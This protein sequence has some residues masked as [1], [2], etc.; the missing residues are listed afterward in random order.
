MPTICPV[1]FGG[2]SGKRKQSQAQ[3]YQAII[4]SC[5]ILTLTAFLLGSSCPPC[6]SNFVLSPAS[7]PSS[8]FL[9]HCGSVCLLPTFFIFSSLFLFTMSP[10]LLFGH[11]FALPIE[12]SIFL[13][14]Y[15]WLLF[16]FKLSPSPGLV[17]Q[18]RLDWLSLTSEGVKK[19]ICCL[20]QRQPS[21]VSGP[22]PSANCGEF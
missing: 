8:L 7:L 9:S 14:C 10:I 15:I 16:F 1:C 5:N 19:L 4:G 22:D 21:P 11:C 6:L 12:W 2:S 3:T 18:R 17:L 13:L 20:I